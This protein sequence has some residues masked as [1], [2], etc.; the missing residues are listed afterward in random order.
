MCQWFGFAVGC[1][2]GYGFSREP[3]CCSCLR[4]LKWLQ[5]TP[6]IIQVFAFTNHTVLPEALEKW[7]VA[8]F[9]KLLPRHMQIVYDINWRFLQVGQLPVC[10]LLNC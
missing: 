5:C 8:L 4:I 3:A 2:Q 6:P 10:F 7:P 9:E 1:V